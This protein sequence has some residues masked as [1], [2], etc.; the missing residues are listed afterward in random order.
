MPFTALAIMAGVAAVVPLLFITRLPA[1]LRG[2]AAAAVPFALFVGFATMLP[3][4]AAGMI[5]TDAL[6]WVPSLGV[7]LAFRV[8]GLS[9]LM[10]LL[11]TGIGAG[12]FAFSGRYL[13]SHPRQGRFLAVLSLFMAAMLGTVTSDHLIALFVFWEL[14]SL[15]SFL[16]IGFKGESAKARAAAL[17]ALLVTGAGGLMLLAA[18]A[19]YR[20]GRSGGG[21]AETKAAPAKSG[22]RT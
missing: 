2:W 14:T 5:P 1:A 15:T 6:R 7:E 18:L 8:D 20:R 12:V 16:L 22:E 17:Q 21:L 3:G 13:A 4:V 11:I 19:D 10:A 9:L